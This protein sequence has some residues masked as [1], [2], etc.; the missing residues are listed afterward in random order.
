MFIIQKPDLIYAP[1]MK[2]SKPSRRMGVGGRLF[3]APGQRAGARG[4]GG[5]DD[6]PKV[7]RTEGPGGHPPGRPDTSGRLLRSQAEHGSEP[8]KNGIDGPYSKAGSCF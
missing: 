8:G 4:L 6:H 7:R 1:P 5:A 3:Y 2:T